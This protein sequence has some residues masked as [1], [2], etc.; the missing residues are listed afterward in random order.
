MLAGKVDS[1][2]RTLAG[3]APGKITNTFERALFEIGDRME[4][5]QMHGAIATT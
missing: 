4:A 2:S 5:L 3:D 1:C